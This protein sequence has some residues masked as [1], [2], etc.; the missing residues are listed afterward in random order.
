VVYGAKASKRFFEEDGKI[1]FAKN[2]VSI[3][4]WY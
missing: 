1:L 3:L 4:G 2:Q